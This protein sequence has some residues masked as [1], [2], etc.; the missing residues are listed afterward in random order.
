[1]LK[2]IIF[3]RGVGGGEGEVVGFMVGNFVLRRRDS[4]L[5]QM[6]FFIQLSPF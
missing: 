4:L 5:P 2:F 3:L 1:M 6:S